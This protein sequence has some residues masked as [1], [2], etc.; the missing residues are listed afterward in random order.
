MNFGMLW[1]DDDKKRTFEEKVLRAADYYRS[2][3][4]RLP[5]TCYVHRS[6]T[7]EATKINK[8]TVV[9]DQTVLPHHFLLALSQ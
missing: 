5:N 2:K 3:Y 7:Q 8:I 6:A 1:L 4:G 9:P